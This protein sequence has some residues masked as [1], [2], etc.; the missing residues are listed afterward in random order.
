MYS[1]SISI[2]YVLSQYEKAIFSSSDFSWSKPK[3]NA[4]RVTF[5]RVVFTYE[6]G[7]VSVVLVTKHRKNTL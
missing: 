7:C 1:N 4:E 5:H 6:L 2:M 3:E